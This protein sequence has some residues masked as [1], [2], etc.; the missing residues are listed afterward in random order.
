MREVCLGDRLRAAAKFVRQDAVFADIGTDHAYL[1]LFLL[2]EGKVRMAVCTDVNEG[3]LNTARINAEDHGI[4]DNI[5]FILTDG[6]Y[7]LE[8]YGITDFAIC[9]M[10]GELIARI[11]DDSAF[12]KKKGTRLILEP[13]SRQAHLRRF[14][15][16]E[17]FGITEEE[18]V[19]DSGKFYLIIV[20]EY[21]GEKRKIDPTEAELGCHSR[22]TGD[23][24]AKLGYL[25][26]KRKALI[27]ARDG[28]L[29]GKQSAEYED[30]VLPAL[31]RAIDELNK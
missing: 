2:A 4:T 13:M 19:T 24:A 14:L 16:E 18:Y 11:I 9:G 21:N 23:T 1:P 22:A 26:A 7:G 28:K 12:L 25:N 8:E 15:A 10:G 29:S 6:A 3:P 27:K 5:K 30:L 31:D 20:A 17:G